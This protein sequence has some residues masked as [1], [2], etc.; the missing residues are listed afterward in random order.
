MKGR[1]ED[2]MFRTEE[3]QSLKHADLSVRREVEAKCEHEI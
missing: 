3:L 1:Q 2:K